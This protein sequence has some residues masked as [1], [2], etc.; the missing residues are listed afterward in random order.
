MIVHFS[1]TIPQ[2]RVARA[3]TVS[4]TVLQRGFLGNYIPEA[5]AV[6]S[7]IIVPSGGRGSRE[8]DRKKSPA[9]R[10]ASRASESFARL[11]EARRLW[12]WW[13][14]GVRN[15]PVSTPLLPAPLYL[16]PSPSDLLPRV[17]L[18]HW[19]ILGRPLTQTI[20]RIPRL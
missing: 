6:R 15:C 1:T 17:P 19:T 18:S 3:F 7:E 20:I 8:K 2:A 13:S 9:K 14:S 10:R 4:E 12:S 16:C 11:L 5:R